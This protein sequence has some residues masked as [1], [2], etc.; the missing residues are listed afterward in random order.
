M[1]QQGLTSQL[2][3]A[4]LVQRPFLGSFTSAG[5]QAIHL[6][7]GLEELKKTAGMAALL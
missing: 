4:K 5:G 6:A 2:P 1:Q 7:A 3:I